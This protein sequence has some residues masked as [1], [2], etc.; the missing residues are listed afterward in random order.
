M[1]LSVLIQPLH[2]VRNVN[3]KDMRF[4]CPQVSL[5]VDVKHRHRD[6]HRIYGGDRTRTVTMKA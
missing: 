4:S 1:V 6:G 5:Q 3:L 2:S